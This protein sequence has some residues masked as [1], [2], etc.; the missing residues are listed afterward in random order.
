MTQTDLADAAAL[1][2][3]HVNRSLREL[4]KLGLMT[5][6]GNSLTIH[7]WEG[8]K[9]LAEFDPSYLQLGGV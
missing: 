5:I 8:I 6:S 3:V 7:D 1:S 9:Q 4:R 2:L